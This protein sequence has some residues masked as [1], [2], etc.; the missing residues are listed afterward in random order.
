MLE[1]GAR[2]GRWRVL[3]IDAI[4][5]RAAVLCSCGAA[6]IVTIASLESGESRSCG[7][8]PL[9]KVEVERRRREPVRRLPNWKPQQ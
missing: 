8:A 7:C 4:A 6:R 1:P 3:T 9:S 5:H 2:Y